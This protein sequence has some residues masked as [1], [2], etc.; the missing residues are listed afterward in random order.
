MALAAVRHPKIADRWSQRHIRRCAT[1][2]LKMGDFKPE[3]TGK[4]NFYLSAIDDMLRHPQDQ[5]TV[6]II[7][8]KK[9]HN[10]VLVEYAL[11]DTR[12][13][14]GVSEFRL[15][16]ALPANFRGTLPSIKELETAQVKRS[17]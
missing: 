13:P 11:R 10:K 8:C 9:A 5:P 16:V 3:Y 4:M 17:H 1:E 12:K 7:L 2:D 14:I 15:A 6:G